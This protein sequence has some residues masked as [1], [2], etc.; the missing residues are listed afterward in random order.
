MLPLQASTAQAAAAAALGQQ[1]AAVADFESAFL[2]RTRAEQ[3][4]LVE[5][6]SG[7]LAGWVGWPA[8]F[9][10]YCGS[11]GHVPFALS[12]LHPCTLGRSAQAA[13]FPLKSVT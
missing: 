4:A 11:A 7:L 1:A 3:A 10:D 13:C 8:A 6:I 5:Q 12:L 2:E 9:E